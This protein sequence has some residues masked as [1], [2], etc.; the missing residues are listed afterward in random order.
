VLRSH[1]IPTEVALFGLTFGIGLSCQESGG[2]SGSLYGQFVGEAERGWNIICKCWAQIGYASQQECLAEGPSSDDAW[3]ECEEQVFNGS[4]EDDAWMRCV[5]NARRQMNNCVSTL[6]CDELLDYYGA[7]YDCYLDYAEAYNACPELPQGVYDEIDQCY[8]DS[9]FDCADG[10][11]SI[12][13]DWVCDG[14]A[15]CPDGSDEAS[16]VSEQKGGVRPWK[17][18]RPRLYAAR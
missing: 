1:K 10:L 11:A 5:T 13:P 3:S 12:P 9:F 17:A 15:D 4:S 6:S 7:F 18:P 2:G 14:E 16:C 8:Q